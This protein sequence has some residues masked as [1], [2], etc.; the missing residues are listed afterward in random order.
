MSHSDRALA[1]SG[2]LS[3]NVVRALLAEATRR[4]LDEAELR[5][6]F[7]IPDEVVRDVDSRVSA[8]LL[9]RL[10]SELPVLLHDDDFGLHLGEQTSETSIPLAGKLFEAY[11]TVGDGLGKLVEFQRLM[12]DVHPTL[13]ERGPGEASISVRSKGSAIPAPRH[14]VEFVFAWMLLFT[15]RTTGVDFIPLRVGFEHGRPRDTREHA[16]IFNCPVHFDTERAE[17]VVAS[18]VLDLR[19]R[20]ADPALVEILESHARTLVARL[21]DRASFAARVRD[22]VVPLLPEGAGIEAVA[23][24]MRLSERS[25]QRYLQQE[26]TSLAEVVA[27]VRRAR[28]EAALRDTS[29][30]IATL[31]ASLGFSDQSAFHK[32]FARWTGM[33]PGAFRKAA[34]GSR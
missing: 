25:V 5:Q 32:A 27:E 30:P 17:M 33:T 2:T 4:G 29:V 28:A 20:N 3:G 11:A 7:A 22:A 19:Q 31:S 21:P 1:A 24:A 10:W 8:G 13:L 23:R 18:S 12:N 16:R 14:A 9:V 34:A 26:G 6:R 15:R